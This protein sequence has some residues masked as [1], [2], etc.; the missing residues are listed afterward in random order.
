MGL[1]DCPRRRARQTAGDRSDMRAR[2]EEVLKPEQ[3]ARYAEI[4]A[5]LGGRRQRSIHARPDLPD[6]KRKPKAI[7]VR[8]GLSDGAMSE[9][10]GEGLAEGAEVIVGLQGAG[11]EHTRS[12]RQPPEDVFQS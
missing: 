3:K 11:G 6:G 2:V 4:V 1:R 8:V 10:A 7:E 12:K 9:V 5:E